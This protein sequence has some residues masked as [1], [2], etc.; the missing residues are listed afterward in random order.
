MSDSIDSASDSIVDVPVDVATE[1]QD[2]AHHTNGHSKSPY[3]RETS[4]CKYDC[5]LVDHDIDANFISISKYRS[6]LVKL[7]LAVSWVYWLGVQ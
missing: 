5:P 7:L 6:L 4:S 3:V 2:E 1:P